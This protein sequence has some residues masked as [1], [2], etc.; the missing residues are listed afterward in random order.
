MG[1]GETPLTKWRREW[2]TAHENLSY[3]G[4]PPNCN[5]WKI[6]REEAISPVETEREAPV[7]Q[8]DVTGRTHQEW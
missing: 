3:I 1:N 6:P 4:E 7:L 5:K 2:V 8:D